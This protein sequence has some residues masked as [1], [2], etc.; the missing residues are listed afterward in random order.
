MA[1]IEEINDIY[2]QIPT[3][4]PN[5]KPIIDKILSSLVKRAYFNKKKSQKKV[6]GLNNICVNR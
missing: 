5:Y 1:V 6:I 3:F 4:Y 2:A